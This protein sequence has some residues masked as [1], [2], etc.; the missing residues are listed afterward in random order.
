VNVEVSTNRQVRMELSMH[1]FV[2]AYFWIAF[3][4]IVPVL[5]MMIPTSPTKDR[6]IDISPEAK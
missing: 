4:E 3:L 5:S 6:G 2:Y 1:T